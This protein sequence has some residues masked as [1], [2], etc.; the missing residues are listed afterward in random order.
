MPKDYGYRPSSGTGG[1]FETKDEPAPPRPARPVPAS[2]PAL[3]LDKGSRRRE[4]PLVGSAK[5]TPTEVRITVWRTLAH[6]VGGELPRVV[7]EQLQD[8]ALRKEVIYRVG[9]KLGEAGLRGDEVAQ[10][11]DRLAILPLYAQEVLLQDDQSRN[12]G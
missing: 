12:V 3:G 2:I 11:H 10:A 7:A 9:Q 6:I 1:T 8:E 4:A 5:Y